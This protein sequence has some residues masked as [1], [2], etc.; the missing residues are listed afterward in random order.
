[1]FW[2]NDCPVRV[3]STDVCHLYKACGDKLYSSKNFG[4][5][6]SGILK[7][8]LWLRVTKVLSIQTPNLDSSA[9][10]LVFKSKGKVSVLIVLVVAVI[11][12]RR[13]ICGDTLC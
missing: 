13:L 2:H 3:V 4:M 5:V 8:H 9:L 6:A 1:M 7:C 10:H 12:I 11:G